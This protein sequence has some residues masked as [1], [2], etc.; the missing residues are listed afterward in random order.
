MSQDERSLVRG[1]LLGPFS[2]ADEQIP[3]AIR[4]AGLELK[5]IGQRSEPIRYLDKDGLEWWCLL[6]LERIIPAEQ[7]TLAQVR[8]ELTQ[9]V[10]E[11]EIRQRM[12]QLQRQLRK[13]A[14]VEV[15]D[16]ILK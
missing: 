2:Q 11:R 7:V 8:Q 3:T 15:V 16:P 5:A 4:Q 14:R 13:N 12:A 1:G 9:R 6:Q 10:R